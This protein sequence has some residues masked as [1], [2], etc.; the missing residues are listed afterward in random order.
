MGEWVLYRYGKQ[1]QDTFM[2]VL[3]QKAYFAV[4]VCKSH[5]VHLYLYHGNCD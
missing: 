2:F 5:P 3:I 1:G 4:P